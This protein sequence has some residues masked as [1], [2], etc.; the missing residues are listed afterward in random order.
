MKYQ[1]RLEAI[2]DVEVEADSYAEAEDK[3][4]YEVANEFADWYI[5]SNEE[6]G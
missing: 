3:A 5:I 1:V 4:L 6:V 2:T